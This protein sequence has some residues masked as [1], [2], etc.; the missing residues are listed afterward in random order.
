MNTERKLDRTVYV[1]EVFIA[2]GRE[3]CVGNEEE[4]ENGGHQ[5]EERKYV[6]TKQPAE[7]GAKCIAA[8]TGPAQ[9]QITNN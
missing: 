2:R 4:E 7:D 8:M 3:R 1:K 6:E 5:Q 9:E